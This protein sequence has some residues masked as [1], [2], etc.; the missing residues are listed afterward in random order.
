MRRL[1]LSPGRF[2]DDHAGAVIRCLAEHGAEKH[3][4]GYTVYHLITI[5]IASTVYTLAL[6]MSTGHISCIPY[7][8]YT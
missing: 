7:F 6:L 5:E 4:A 3:S 1:F 2:K 8:V